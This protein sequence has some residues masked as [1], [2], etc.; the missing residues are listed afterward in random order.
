MTKKINKRVIAGIKNIQSL[1]DQLQ[2]KKIAIVHDF[3][4]Q[5]GG[6]EYVVSVL[7]EMFPGAPIYTSIYQKGKTWSA[8]EN[9]DIR[10]SWMQK[11]PFVHKF[12]KKL[13][14][15]YPLAFASFNL[16]EYDVILSSSSSFAKGIHRNEN[17]KHI[18]YCH[19]PARFLYKSEE[20][21]KK[22]KMPGLFRWLLPLFIAPLKKWDLNSNSQVDGFITN[23]VNIQQ[24]IDNTYGVDS[25]VVYPPVDISRFNISHNSEDFYLIV[26]RILGYKNIDLV[27][28]ACNKLKKNLVII[29]DG[30]HL[31]HIKSIAGPTVAVLGRQPNNIVE[32]YIGRCKA[33]IFPGNEDFGISPIEAQAAGKPVV[34]LRAGGALETIKE[35]QTGVFFDEPKV[36]LLIEALNKLDKKRWNPKIIR[37]NAKNYSKERF[38]KEM[39]LNINK[40]ILG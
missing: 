21:L 34:A 36:E 16:A 35:G 5:Q 24:R 14:F 4:N 13:F 29:G 7:H 11:I 3:L 20:Y 10:V 18:C 12:F 31:E 25:T 8:L 38:M 39:V 30:P 17:Q 9:A 32:D 1:K 2:G 23:S 22:E 15:L 40:M 19:T 6:A 27:I 26:S 37:Q 33:F 28:E